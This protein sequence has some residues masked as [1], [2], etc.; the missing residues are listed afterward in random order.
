MKNVMLT[1]IMQD[2][3]DLLE[4]KVQN[5]KRALKAMEEM[6]ETRAQE[7]MN[8]DIALELSRI[9]HLKNKFIQQLLR[10]SST[11]HPQ[12]YNVLMQS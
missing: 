7:P 11:L 6:F 8:N 1:Q 3:I 10:E 9:I 5:R 2:N 12:V 4:S